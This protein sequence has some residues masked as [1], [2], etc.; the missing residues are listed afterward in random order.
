[1]TAFFKVGFYQANEFFIVV[2]AV[3]EENPEFPGFLVMVRETA[4]TVVA[5][6]PI[7]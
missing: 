5:A 4:T 3:T 1:M 6:I 7:P 2:V